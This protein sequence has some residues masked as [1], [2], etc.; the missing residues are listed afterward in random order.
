MTRPLIARRAFA[1]ILAGFSVFVAGCGG[2]GSSSGGSAGWR[3]VNLS[4]DI[5][6]VDVYANTTKTQTGVALDSVTPY[7]A[8]N[9]DSYTLKVTASNDTASVLAS[10][11]TFSPS[12]DKNYSAIITGRSGSARLATLLDD[13]DTSGT[14]VGT[15]RV[16]VYNASPESGPIDVYI[17]NVA[18]IAEVTPN[19]SGLGAASVSGFRDV[20]AATY[21]L[22]V[23]G[24]GDPNDVR[25]DVPGL[26]LASK[27]ASTLV[28]SAGVSGQLANAA[29]IVQGGGV[30]PLKNTQARVRVVAGV[31]SSALVS[32]SVGGTEVVSGGQRSPSLGSYARIESQ[33]GANQPVALSVNGTPVTSFSRSFVAGGDYTVIVYGTTAAPQIQVLTD[34]NRLPATGRYRMRLVHVDSSLGGLT[35]QV[36]SQELDPV[37]DVQPGTTSGF[38]TAASNSTALLEVI[39]SSDIRQVYSKSDVNL[40]SQGVYSLFVIGGKTDLS[41]NPITTVQL[42]KDR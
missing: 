29:K 35:L 9:V 10:T 41:N 36:D 23:T 12:K 7:Q 13:E 39:T 33:A 4:N 15:A 18:D 42:R 27:E 34:D 5:S 21:R 24:A 38:A 11:F 28:I 16:R 37:V 32:V 20:S 3:V 17:T 1:V 31:V 22:R 8:I 19:I 40:A 14:A 30:T 2:G 6:P 25:L 26:V